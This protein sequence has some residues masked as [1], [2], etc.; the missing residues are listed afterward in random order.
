MRGRGEGLLLKPDYEGPDSGFNITPGDVIK[1]G[2]TIFGGLGAAIGGGYGLL[3]TPHELAAARGFI[4]IAGALATAGKFG[5]AGLS[6]GL[7]VGALVTVPAALVLYANSTVPAPVMTQLP[8][9]LDV[10]LTRL[11]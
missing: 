10:D 4:A 2:M 5:V 3:A 11:P 9:K 7:G 8:L 1:E 6:L